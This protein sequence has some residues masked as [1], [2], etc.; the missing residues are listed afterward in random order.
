MISQ[1][2][3]QLAL[4]GLAPRKRRRRAPAERR[5]APHDPIA[6]VVLDVQATHLGRTFDYLI[7]DKDD[8]AAK[9]GVQV[10]VRFGGQRL[11]GVIW[12]RVPMESATAPRSSLRFLERVLSP[13]VV[14]GGEMRRDIADIADWYGGTRANILRVAVPPR[15]ARVEKEQAFAG[16]SDG[17]VGSCANRLMDRLA[18]IAGAEGR[19]VD[20]SYDQAAA[21]RN[22]LE[23]RG[24]AQVVVDCLPGPLIW[25]RDLAWAVAEV[26]GAGKAAVAVLP[27]MRH[28]EDV[29][30][31]LCTMGLR[32][33]APSDAR[34]G[35][36]Q[37]DFVTLGAALPPDERYRAYLAVSSGHVRCVLGTRAAMYAPVTG[38]A[39][40]AIVDDV[41]YQ[42]A[43]GFMP[44]A[45]ARGVL[46]LR[47]RNHGGVFMAI[48]HARSPISEA[49]DALKVH[50]LPAVTKDRSPWIRWLN[51]EALN[52]IH[53]TT[54]G[55]RVP[56]TAVRVLSKALETGPILLSIPADGVSETL[57]CAK[58]HRQARCPKCTGPL[59]AVRGWN[60]AR[61][62]W[63]GAAAVHWLCPDCRCDRMR[64]V[65]VGAAGTAAELQGLFRGVPIVVSSP[66]QPRGVIEEIADRPALVIATPGAEPRVR[67]VT[68]DGEASDGSVSVRSADDSPAARLQAGYQAVAI[69]DAW[70][71]LYALGVD[72][73]TDTLTAWMRAVA[74]CRPRTAGGQALLLGETDPVLAEAL[75]GWN[76]PV[77]AAREVA[78]R[79]EAG[80]PPAVA[81]ACVWG[82]RDAVMWALGQ[83]GVLLDGDWG[84]VRVSDG[85]VVPNGSGDDGVAADMDQPAV[86]GPVPIPQP[87]TINARELEETADRVKAVVRV[88]PDRRTEL[89]LRLRSAV[90]K[91]VATRT[92]GELRFQLDPK[93]LI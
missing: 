21:W 60:A 29:A 3:E 46:R 66:N 62:R 64:V 9:P 69:L 83:T 87:A 10:R 75:C 17:F 32:R 50:A 76:A 49:S 30:E 15:V 23:G 59:E 68:G 73:L 2:A 42:N 14:V 85:A 89:A 43:D 78:D 24:F 77:L 45:Q 22:A 1:D 27:D 31:V 4:D 38:P 63:C 93:D 58:C 40:F 41:A 26:M 92:P 90:A 82:R 25:A 86:L 36:W 61:C 81:A 88:S 7:E 44:Y 52:A 5:P 48:G 6:Q 20:A 80:L 72:A 8:E 34:H 37:G 51:R 84:M 57:S 39:L 11:N 67:P 71:S 53:D 91:H 16:R 35:G 70:T 28:V 54:A 47:A 65:R 74:L 33:F 13:V 12:N 56:H 19:R 55:T 18:A 79:R